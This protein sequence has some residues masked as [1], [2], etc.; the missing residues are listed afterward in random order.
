MK[1]RYRLFQRSSGIFFIEDRISKKQES[2]KTRD[3]TAAQRVFN[4]RNEAHQQPAVLALDV[5]R[6]QRRGAEAL[7]IPR[8]LAIA[9]AHFLHPSDFPVLDCDIHRNGGRGKWIGER[10]N[11][12]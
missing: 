6:H 8:I 10:G 3:K 9:D 7:V 4:A 1:L 11:F 2:L 12:Y 5:T